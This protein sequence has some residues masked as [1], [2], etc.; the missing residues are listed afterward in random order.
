MFRAAMCP[1]SG[2]FLYQCDIWFMSLCVDDRLVCRSICFCMFI[3]ILYMFRA[4]MCP[5]SGEFLYQCDIWFMSLWVDDRL[6]CSSICFC[7][8]ISILYMFRAAMCPSSGELL[9]QCDTSFMSLW[10]DDRPVCSSMLLHMLLHTRRSSP[11]SDKARCRIDTIIL[12]M[13][14]TW[15]RQTCREQKRTYIKNVR[16]VGY[17]QVPYQDARSTKYKIRN[18]KFIYVTVRSDT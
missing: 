8:F 3:S 18:F 15:L 9:Y 10:V 13:M 5:S 14:G 11:Q 2:E 4:T 1:S 12:L 6:V 7:M 16:Q 17:L